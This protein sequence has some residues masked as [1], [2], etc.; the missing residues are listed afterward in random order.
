MSSR[1]GEIVPKSMKAVYDEIVGM[2]DAFCD[3]HL[4]RDY[5]GLCA[6]M[7]RSWLASVRARWAA[8]RCAHGLERFSIR[9]AGPTFCLTNRS[10]RT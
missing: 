9:S 10:I 7:A 2:T 8:D 1:P 3:E 4:D 5:S 6:K